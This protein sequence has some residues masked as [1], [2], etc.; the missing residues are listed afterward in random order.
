MLGRLATLLLIMC[1]VDCAPHTTTGTPTSPL[2]KVSVT[3]GQ[4]L[5]GIN[6]SIL[7]V[8]ELNRNKIITREEADPIMSG[9]KQ[10]TLGTVAMNNL[11]RKLNTL[12]DSDKKDLIKA[13]QPAFDAVDEL[14]SKHVINLGA[15]AQARLKVLLV[16]LQS[17]LSLLKSIT[18]V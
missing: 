16:A 18:V 8:D 3:I 14:V 5:A 7:A 13:G 1:I 9:L 15:N 4:V 11:V 10:A 6:E 12:S 17:S 2:L